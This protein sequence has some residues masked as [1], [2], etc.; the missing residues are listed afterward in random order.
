MIFRTGE[1]SERMFYRMPRNITG[2]SILPRPPVR[3]LSLSDLMVSV[4]D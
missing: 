2:L 3:I 1:M 4:S